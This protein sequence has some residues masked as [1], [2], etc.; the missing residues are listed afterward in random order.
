MKTKKNTVETVTSMGVLVTDMGFA[1][2]FMG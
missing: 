1:V 2:T